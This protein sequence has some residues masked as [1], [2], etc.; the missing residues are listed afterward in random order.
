MPHILGIF[1]HRLLTAHVLVSLNMGALCK[2]DTTAMTAWRLF[3]SQSFCKN[4]KSHKCALMYKLEEETEIC[5]HTFT[6]AVRI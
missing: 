4:E 6:L 2:P 5:M 3:M 1:N